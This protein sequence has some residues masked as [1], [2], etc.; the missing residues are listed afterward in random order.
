MCD[1]W[2]TQGDEKNASSISI[3]FSF[4]F[5]LRNENIIPEEH[6]TKSRLK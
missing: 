6:K 3:V 2:D 4:D 5:L 1:P